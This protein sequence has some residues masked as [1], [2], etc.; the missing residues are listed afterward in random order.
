MHRLFFM[1]LI[2]IAT[3]LVAASPLTKS[4]IDAPGP[5]GPLKGT[6]FTSASAHAPV[7]L[8]V[9]GSGPTDRDGNGAGGL[10]ASTYRLLAEG[11]AARGIGSLR[12]DKRGMFG[13][14][15]AV[16]DANAVTLDDY[17][18]D[19]HTWIAALLERTETRC[20][21][22]LGHSEGG[23][24]GLVAAQRSDDI[25]GLILLS[26]PG[27]PLGAVLREQLRANP[28]NAPILDQALSAIASLEGGHRVDPASLNP[29]L[30]PL[31]R[32]E[33][34]GFLINAFTY[35]PAKLIGAVLVPVLILQGDRDIQV[36]V[37]D[38][39]RLKWAAQS[40][41]LKIVAHANHVW[42]TVATDD[43]GANL[44]TYADPS[45][46]LASGL[47]D[48]VGAFVTQIRVSGH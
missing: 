4:E 21:W 27:R 24:V 38:A 9:P 20:V 41:T 37:D 15:G 35:D 30:L 22:V 34:Q 48:E 29:A 43:L 44:A 2:V 14:S 19:V 8:I 5:L 12:I 42:K 3:P 11:L 40:A 46:P 17:A 23:L 32:P 31:F 36:S 6:L 13:S 16:A 33:V 1:A 10:N 26:T 18:R 45:L 25:C 7:V 39:K 28:A 47:A